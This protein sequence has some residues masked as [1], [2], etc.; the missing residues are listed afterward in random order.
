MRRAL[1]A[2]GL[3]GAEEDN[4]S[5]GS[6][7]HFFQPVDPAYRGVCEC[8]ATEVQMADPDG[9]RWSQAIDPASCSTCKLYALLG[10][11]PCPLHA[12]GVR[13]SSPGEDIGSDMTTIYADFNA[14]TPDGRVRLSTTGSRASLSTSSVGP[15]CWVWLSDGEV[16][17]RALIEEFRGELLARVAWNTSEDVV[18]DP[19]EISRAEAQPMAPPPAPTSRARK[20]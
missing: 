17:I 5:P 15:G 20:R 11:R 9:Y 10:Q 6:A 4:H 3:V 1:R 13:I 8:K 7:R 19:G 16:R 2:F 14:R 18:V 12:H